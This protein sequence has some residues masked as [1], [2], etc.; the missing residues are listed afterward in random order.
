MSPSIVKFSPISR[1][2]TVIPIPKSMVVHCI[3]ERLS[4]PTAAST[5]YDILI[6]HMYASIGSLYANGKALAH[7]SVQCGTVHVLNQWRVQ[8]RKNG[9]TTTMFEKFSEVSL[10]LVPWIPYIVDINMLSQMTVIPTKW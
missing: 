9:G 5:F 2:Q 1:G 4:T 8:T 6:A 10:K 3:R 7:L